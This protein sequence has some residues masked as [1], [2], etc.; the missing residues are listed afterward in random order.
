MST[1]VAT[2]EHVV[3]L[4]SRGHPDGTAPKSTVHDG[5]TPLHL[6]FSCH[7]VDPTGRVLLTRRAATKR[8]WP[9]TWSNA[10]C[11][12]PQLGETL[13]EAVVRRLDDELG[14]RPRRLAV[15]LPDFAYRAAMPDGTVEHELC[16]VVV[17][18]VDEE[19]APNLGEV[20]AVEWW[21]W[22]RLRRRAQNDPSSL[23]PWSVQQIAELS[24]LA[25][26]PLAWLDRG[27]GDHG[28]DRPPGTGVRR[29]TSRREID[30]AVAVAARP[31]EAR[32]E[33]F[34]RDRVAATVECDPAMA[35]VTDAICGPSHAAASACGPRSSTGATPPPARVP[36]T[37]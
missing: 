3:L 29:Q 5:A 22:E 28:L 31:V 16:P 12:H 27:V 32:L 13:R 6:A 36:T 14:L 23:S 37:G 18:E 8:T 26:S 9:A 17:A 20:D 25:E 30:E 1:P 35:P 34:L 7:V 10:C 15:A 4:D 33:S 2:H 11:G 24:Q 21:D 19:P